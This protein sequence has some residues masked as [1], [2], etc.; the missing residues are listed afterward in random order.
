MNDPSFPSLPDDP[1][2]PVT[3]TRRQ[4]EAMVR[5]AVRLALEEVTRQTHELVRAR[6]FATQVPAT[7][8]SH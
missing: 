4:L 2:A 6:D 3:L 8:R 1:D 7:D 5:A